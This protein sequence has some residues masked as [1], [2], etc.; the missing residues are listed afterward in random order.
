MN[1]QPRMQRQCSLMNA[2]VQE[3][4]QRKP[5]QRF[6]P[7][8]VA[9]VAVVELLNSATAPLWERETVVLTARTAA[10]ATMRLAGGSGASPA[11]LHRQAAGKRRCQHLPSI[12]RAQPAH[13]TQ[14]ALSKCHVQVVMSSPGGGNGHDARNECAYGNGDLHL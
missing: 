11:G 14:E 6:S 2:V 4:R 5:Q 1:R 12:W 3:L 13:Y 10:S 8:A 9:L 7:F